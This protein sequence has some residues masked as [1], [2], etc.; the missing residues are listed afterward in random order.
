MLY[1]AFIIILYILT[2]KKNFPFFYV[3]S[4]NKTHIHVVK[5]E[6]NLNCKKIVKKIVLQNKHF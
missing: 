1:R 3:G 2:K 6:E 5:N 4:T